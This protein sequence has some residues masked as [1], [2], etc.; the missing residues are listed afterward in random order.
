M[1][2]TIDDFLQ[3]LANDGYPFTKNASN[4]EFCIQHGWHHGAHRCPA[5]RRRFLALLRD[6][7]KALDRR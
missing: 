3:G 7:N 2:S 4:P 5:C 1:N 6:T